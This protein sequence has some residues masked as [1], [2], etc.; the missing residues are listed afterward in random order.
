MSDLVDGTLNING[1]EGLFSQP[2]GYAIIRAQVE[3]VKGYDEDQ[4]ALVIPDLT[5]FGLRDLVTLVT[6]TIN[7]IMNMI[8]ENKID[9]LSVS[10]NGS[11]IPYLLIGH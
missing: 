11:R 3:G 4:V 7:Q 9:G 1:F 2:L 10:L 8:K 6:P 5:T